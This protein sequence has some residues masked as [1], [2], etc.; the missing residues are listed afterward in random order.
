MIDPHFLRDSVSALPGAATMLAASIAALLLY[1][2]SRSI[3]RLYLH[4]LS[5]VP[6]PKLAALTP[7]F[8]TYYQLVKGDGGQFYL[9]VHE[10]HKKYGIAP[11]KS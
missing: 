5:N 3:Y 4:P 8:E 11:P 7:W 2:L 10:W 6:G 1:G 9:A